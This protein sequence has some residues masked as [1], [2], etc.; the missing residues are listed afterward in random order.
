LSH[1]KHIYF[2]TYLS[3]IDVFI[4]LVLE[5]VINIIRF[6]KFEL[7]HSF[8]CVF[9]EGKHIVLVNTTH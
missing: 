2:K 8:S 6:S 4:I 1:I 3:I 7:A 5:I 9:M